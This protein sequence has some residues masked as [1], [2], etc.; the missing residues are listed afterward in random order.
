MIN[1]TGARSV[2]RESAIPNR[3]ALRARPGLDRS[4]AALVGLLLADGAIHVLLAPEHFA[5]SPVLGL[6]FLLSGLAQG[7]VAGL[8]VRRSRLPLHGVVAVL[9]AGL[10]LLYGLAITRGLPFPAHHS[11]EHM[12]TPGAMAST[13]G[14][15]AESV[16]L[17]GLTSKAL[18]IA[19][20]ALAL[21][22]RPGRDS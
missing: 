21:V 9:S 12:L 20:L 3:S 19:T 14:S 6:G 15:A 4:R 10:L 16:T 11:G 22:F 17:D 18:E 1:V 8:L 13:G 2:R 7:V 5:Q